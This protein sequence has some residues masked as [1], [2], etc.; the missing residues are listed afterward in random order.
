M[1][2]NRDAAFAAWVGAEDAAQAAIHVLHQRTRGGRIKVAPQEIEQI[3]RLRKEADVRFAAVW[4]VL[5]TSAAA[6]EALP[7]PPPP[8]AE[9]P[10]RIVVGPRAAHGQALPSIAI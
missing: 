6:P 9:R 10:Q 2:D 5:G 3:A 8:R 1:Q 4:G 7:E